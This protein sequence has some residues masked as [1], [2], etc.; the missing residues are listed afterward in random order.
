M[1][2]TSLNP[3][4]FINDSNSLSTPASG[5]MWFENSTPSAFDPSLIEL[6]QQTLISY[7]ESS[8]V[9]TINGT[10]QDDHAL[11]TNLSGARI[12]V[13]MIGFES[14]IFDHVDVHRIDFFGHDGDDIFNNK[15]SITSRAFGHAGNDV[16]R[17]GSG[18]DKLYGGLGDDILVG[19]GGNDVIAGY[20]GNDII[21]GGE[22]NDIIY[23]G[24]GNDLIY[25]GGGNDRIYGDAGNDTIY[26][27]AGD[28][29]IYGGVGNDT[30]YGGAG[31]D[32]LYGGAGSDIIYGQSGNDRLFGGDGHDR[33]YGGN[34]QDRL[35]GGNGNDGLFGGS[36]KYKNYLHGGAGRNRFLVQSG[37]VISD[38]T[39]ADAR[40]VFINRS[41]K[42]TNKEIET[43]DAGLHRLHHRTRNV[44][45]LIDRLSGHD[46]P[47]I[48]VDS[49][50]GGAARNSLR[51]ITKTVTNSQTGVTTTTVRYER[52]ILV[53]EWNENDA[54]R[55][56]VQPFVI[57]H[58][59]SHNWDSVLELNAQR[60]NTGY[61][62]NKFKNQS[63]WVIN[64]PSDG[65][66]RS[67]D[68][69]WWYLASSEFARDFGRYNPAE[70]WATVWEKYFQVGGPN[71]VANGNL[72][73]K[74]LVVDELFTLL[75]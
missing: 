33:L 20:D 30:I 67:G 42:W 11:V 66:R 34:G 40:L 14:R 46:L 50:G 48:K 56:D 17:G 60:S 65:Y 6:M 15:T 22:G 75:S 57:I 24:N 58:E 10:N 70:D 45:L 36:L 29:I 68:K 39:N 53:A 43:V 5:A 3:L 54:Q 4:Q 32:Q 8:K 7:N 31:N 44:K 2:G 61:I 23:G 9:V 1:F 18:N 72:R 16:L 51:T 52:E 74:L 28:D 49:L 73:K 59:I 13:Q 26:G 21:Y 69:K 71:G 62:W 63:K 55:N 47:F 27:N 25:G 41:S 12:R 19:R 64:P 35:Y 38:R 37:D